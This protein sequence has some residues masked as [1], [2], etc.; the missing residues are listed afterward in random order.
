MNVSNASIVGPT[1]NPTKHIIKPAVHTQNALLQ[2]SQCNSKNIIVTNAMNRQLRPQSTSFL[3]AFTTIHK[4][5]TEKTINPI[6][7]K[8][9]AINI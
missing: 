1:I 8:I 2:S 7:K 3:K 6:K 5:P 4:Y 9:L